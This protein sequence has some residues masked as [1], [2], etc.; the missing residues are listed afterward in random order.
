MSLEAVIPKVFIVSLKRIVWRECLKFRGFLIDTA[1]NIAFYTPIW[2]GIYALLG[3]SL[4]Q[5]I[6]LGATGVAINLSLGGVYGRWL[7]WVRKRSTRRSRPVDE[8]SQ[9]GNML[10]RYSDLQSASSR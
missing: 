9:Q 4:E 10:D 3:L 1:A 7:D 6:S 5:I 2:L 8:V